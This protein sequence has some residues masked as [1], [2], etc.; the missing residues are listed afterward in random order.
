MKGTE[1]KK[2]NEANAEEWREGRLGEAIRLR[3]EWKSEKMNER[4][5]MLLGRY[6]RSYQLTH[7]SLGGS[8]GLRSGYK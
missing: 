7:V 8:P 6:R 1:G 5:A 3:K 2:R 4:D